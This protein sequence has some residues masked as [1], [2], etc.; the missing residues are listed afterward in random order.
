MLNKLR[1][2]LESWTFLSQFPMAQEHAAHA[3]F[4]C[5]PQLSPERIA[6]S[7]FPTGPP[8]LAQP[9][10]S[11]PPDTNEMVSSSHL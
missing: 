2:P 1:L 10:A 7:E 11:M 3:I 8:T 9:G 6:N 5:H 4:Q